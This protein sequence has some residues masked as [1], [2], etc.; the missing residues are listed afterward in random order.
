[1]IFV[2]TRGGR[3]TKGGAVN[4]LSKELVKE[5]KAMAR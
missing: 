5:F 2:V 1:M 4:A 3:A